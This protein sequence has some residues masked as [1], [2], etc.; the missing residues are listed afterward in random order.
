[1]LQ[2]MRRFASS[3]VASIF[4]GALAFSFVIWGIA[5]IFRG[6]TDTSIASV[7]GEKIEPGA[8]QQQY[9]T[10]LR[11]AQ[12]RTG[13]R[14]D[15]DTAK[16]MGLQQDALNSLL[17]DT[18]LANIV[19][20]L[21]LVTTDAQ[22]TAYVHSIPNF[23][24]PLGT[25]DHATF[26]QVLQQSGFTE[27]NFIDTV[28]AESTRDQL[29]AAVRNGLALP[30]GYTR[31]LISYLNER[32][33]VQ[34]VDMPATAVA[35]PAAPDDATLAAYVKQHPERY[36]TPE[37]RDVTYATIG[38]DDLTSQM[39]VSDAQLHDEYDLR[40]D[41]PAFGYVVPEKRD[42]Q[43]IS[44][45][46]AA[47]AKAARAKID[48]GMSFADVAKA[49][50]T[51]PTVFT[52][53]AQS[54]LGDRGAAVFALPLNGISQPLK[55][56]SGWELT[57]VTKIAPGVNK[58]FDMVK[59]D[60][61]KEVLQKLAAAKVQDMDN[62]Y[63][64]A[65]SGGASLAE[66]AK[67]VGMKVIHIAAVDD[68][69]LAPDGTHADIPADPEILQQVF[70]ADIGVEGDPFT[71]K[72][73]RSF[74]L[75]VNGQT[76][77]H[78]KPLDAVRA[79]VTVAWQREQQRKLL[80]EKAE[81]LTAAANKA[82]DLS[83]VAKQLGV[84]VQTSPALTRPTGSEAA[85]TGFD[86]PLLL[87]IF[88]AAPGTV[89]YGPNATGDGYVIAK[90]T[91]VFHPPVPTF[92]PRYRQFQNTMSARAGNDLAETFALAAKAQQGVTLNQHAIAQAMGS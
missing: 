64:D 20:K 76:P 29:A 18:A 41:D 22:V 17:A 9:Q 91:G 88:S 23:N 40:K 6:S 44:F 5:D 61:Q 15:A 53:V 13:Q 26:V 54:D 80:T 19:H 86:D 55:N 72:D 3:W 16:R 39:K 56:L 58:T 36:S 70:K 43:T 52:A 74:V 90:I 46:D 75:L 84:A 30:E 14:I 92:D 21:G 27:Q 60:L 49:R 7:G 32:R 24:G 33:A 67:K 65:N 82:P 1:M 51:A 85:P 35:M 11:E 81:A 2:Q 4:L 87:N 71:T 68:N 37:Y 45:P 83:G 66:A 69:G 31:T 63:T 62:A 28:R 50:G 25:F 10:V 57:E 12:N 34:Y 8:Y 73:G 89:V 77:P 79:Q 59:A 38:P 48:A 47:S 78:L 42:I